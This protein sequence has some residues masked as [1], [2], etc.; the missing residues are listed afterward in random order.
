[1][2]SPAQDIDLAALHDA[3]E[4]LSRLNQRHG[5]VVELRMFVGLTVAETVELLQISAATVKAE[6]SMAR[7]WQ[8]AHCAIAALAQIPSRWLLQQKGSAAQT[9]AQQGTLSQP[10]VPL[11]E[12]QAPPAPP[13]AAQS[14]GHT[15]S[16]QQVHRRRS[17]R[18]DR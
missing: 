14:S 4:E 18:P 7:G 16:M 13:V 5:R 9:I 2:A 11:A 1:M 10:G 3:L 8:T 17:R 15:E 6:W 12:Q